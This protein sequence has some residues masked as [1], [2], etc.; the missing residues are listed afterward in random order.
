MADGD[1]M[2]TGGA[3]VRLDPDIA[4]NEFARMADEGYQR[5]R[6][7]RVV[8]SLAVVLAALYAFALVVPKNVLPTILNNAENGYTLSW[9]L[10]SLNEN[11]T[12]LL[13]VFTGQ[14]VGPVSYASTMVQYV[15]VALAGA[16]L[17]LCG[18]VYQGAFKNALVS[19]STLGVMAGATLGMTGCVALVYDDG[20]TSELSLAGAEGAAASAPSDPLSYLLSSCGLALSS[21]LGC[22]LVVGIVLLTLR[23]A[24]GGMSGIMIIV[25]GQVVA[26]VAGAVT[27][28]VRYYYLAVDP[29]GSKASLL[30]ELQIASF[31]RTFTWI[32]LLALGVP[33]LVTFA[34]VMHVR[35]RMMML[36]LDDA[37][38]R[39]MGVDVR[40]TRLA[41]VA[42]CTLL[43]AIIVSFCGSVGFVGFLVP[44][45]ARRMVGPNFQHLLPASVL[46]GAVFV[47]G[48]H[49]LLMVTLGSD[50]QTMTGMFISIA[51]AAVFL[52]TVLK[53]GAR[54]GGFR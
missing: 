32:D 20:A 9:F 15:I 16:G 43:T 52:A 11:V 35:Q 44:H 25:A 47:L 27:N 12:G 13:A 17:A 7:A 3:A 6:A 39:S 31:Y 40:R 21:F 46:L 14:D 23:L 4:D 2:A 10:Q 26:A 42:L 19:P 48:A 53:G 22:L 33:L 41:V 24:R 18:A 50:Y 54:R 49:T 36:S 30:T 1:R 38:S 8:F 5:S 37:E 45:L 51:G 28:S 29:F 34:V